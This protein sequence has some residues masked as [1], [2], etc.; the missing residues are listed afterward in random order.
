MF[1]VR[2]YGY[3]F[4]RESLHINKTLFTLLQMNVCIKVYLGGKTEMT[5]SKWGTGTRTFSSKE[6]K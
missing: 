4:S 5:E 3:V 2:P 1:F 6:Q